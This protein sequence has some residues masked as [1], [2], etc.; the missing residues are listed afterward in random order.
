MNKIEE[1]IV[2]LIDQ[3]SGRI[4]EFAQDIYHNGETGFEETRTAAKVAGFLRSLGLQTD[5]GLAVTG[6]R[7]SVSGHGDSSIAL[8]GE[9]DGI[10]CENHPDA[11]PANGIAHA[12]GHHI[13]LGALIGAAIALSDDI[14]SQSL[15]GNAVFLAVPAEEPVDA[16]LKRRLIS[17]GDIR[18]GSGGKC[19][20]I[21][22][23]VFDNIDAVIVHHIHYSQNDCDVLIGSNSS[24]GYISKNIRIHGRA[25]HAGAAPFDGINALNA[26]SIGL[27]AL[28]YLR[29]TFRDE[30]SVRV[31]PI[32]T[33]GGSVVNVVPDEVVVELMARAKTLAAIKDASEKT[34]RAFRAGAFAVGAKI[35][36]INSPGYLPVIAQAPQKPL[37]EAAAALSGE[38]S[39]LH[40]DLSVH[41]P[42]STDVGDLSHILPVLGFTTGGFTGALHSADFRVTDQYKAFIIPAKMMALTAYSLLKDGAANLRSMR[43][44][45]SPMMTKEKYL[46]YIESNLA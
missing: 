11:N 3:N 36:I 33:K 14:V 5:E 32:I 19:E 7:A 28:A 26:A 37:L 8:I 22:M 35:D 15:G 39:V 9:L 42:L 46:E 41:N 23:G 20:L 34:D 24:N 12:C 4:I 18:Y 31:H 40:A 38:A 43:S 45:F 44:D 1:R 29:E 16:E 13:Q 25:A 10:R 6:V 21:G 2:D 27:T 30:D 17:Q